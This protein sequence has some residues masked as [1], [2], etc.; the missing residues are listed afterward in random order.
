M[1]QRPLWHDVNAGERMMKHLKT[2]WPGVLIALGLLI[3]PIAG[4]ASGQ[5][6][7]AKPK[8]A[9]TTKKTPTKPTKH[10]VVHKDTIKGTAGGEVCLPLQCGIDQDSV[11][12]AVANAVAASEARESWARDA[13]RRI[14]SMDMANRMQLAIDRIRDTY[15]VQR[16][17]MRLDSIDKAMEAASAAELARKR[18]LARGWYVGIAGGA[19]APQR[20][21]RNG[22]TGGWNTTVPLGWDADE[23]PL[24]FRTD[25]SVDHMNGTRFQDPSGTTTSA[26]GDITVWSLNGDLKLRAHAPGA[27][28][29]TN[30]Y[31]LG[32]IGV[33]RVTQGVFGATG[34]NAGQN[35]S[36]DNAK[37]SF[38]WNVGAGVSMAWGRTELFVESRFIEVKSDLGYRM[39]GG[40]GSYTSF[41][42]IVL[43]LSWF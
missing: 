21:L 1:A 18:M 26:S 39:N 14:D 3:G 41:T 38:G 32:G 13:Q 33:H 4:P 36:F 7:P 12:R 17:R 22:Y 24:G 15:A 43:G 25:L 40:V 34:P 8:A 31:V 5:A 37:S 19:S 2:R 35:L 16:D 20:D 30:V 11:D 23:S 28:T 6:V 10:L 29:R 9:D 27:P 42:P